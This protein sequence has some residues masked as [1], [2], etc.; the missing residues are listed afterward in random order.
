[1]AQPRATRPLRDY[2]AIGDGRTVALI[3]SDG[4]VD[5]LP[6]PDLGSIPAFAA[7]VDAKTGGC[8]ELAPEEPA[9]TSR[10]YVDDTNVLE[11]TFV[12]ESGTVT[13]TDALVTG[14]AGRLPWAELARRI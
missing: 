8:I 1:M 11:T 12:T 6:V 14:I 7:L 5:W 13:V 2:A 4:S 10:R 9:E 3:A